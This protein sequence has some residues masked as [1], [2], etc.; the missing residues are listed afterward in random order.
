MRTLSH[1]TSTHNISTVLINTAVG[2]RTSYAAEPIAAPSGTWTNDPTARS[3]LVLDQPS[4]FAAN[5]ARPALGKPFTYCID[6]YL[7]L[8]LLPK[9]KRDSEIV[10]GGKMGRVELVNAVEVLGDRWEGRVGRWAAFALENG[11]ELRATF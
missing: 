3:P 1:F 10:Y 4:L 7:L 11:V 8:S 9:R 5:M 6:L 2:A